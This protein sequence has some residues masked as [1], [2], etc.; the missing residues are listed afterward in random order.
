MK[1]QRDYPQDLRIFAK[2]VG[3]PDIL[4]CD[5]HPSKKNTEVKDFLKKIGTTLPLLEKN[6]QWSNRAELYL[7]PSQEGCKEGY[8]FFWITSSAMGLCGGAPCSYHVSHGLRH[9]SA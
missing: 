8:V 5:P 7:G 4:V 1:N 9:I 3:S 6:S 2:D